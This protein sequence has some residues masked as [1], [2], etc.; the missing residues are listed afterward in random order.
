MFKKEFI[1]ESKMV[2]GISDKSGSHSLVTNVITVTQG[3]FLR[4]LDRILLFESILNY[5][6]FCWY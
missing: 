4:I 2:I 5:L 1:I 6:L 3:W